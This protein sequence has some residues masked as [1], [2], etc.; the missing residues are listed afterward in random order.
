MVRSPFTGRATIQHLTQTLLYLTET[1]G[2]AGEVRNERALFVYNRVQNK[3]T[4]TLTCRLNLLESNYL[5]DVTLIPMLFF[6]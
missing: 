3:L 4:G 6:P 1:R 2:E 5:Q